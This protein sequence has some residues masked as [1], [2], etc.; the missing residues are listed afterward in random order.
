MSSQIHIIKNNEWSLFYLPTYKQY[1]LKWT[2]PI[3]IELF[4]SF[5][6]V[7]T[8]CIITKSQMDIFF[9]ADTVSTLNNKIEFPTQFIYYISTQCQNLIQNSNYCFFDLIPDYILCI[10]KTKYVYMSLKTL[11]T[12]FNQT[13]KK[14]IQILTPYNKNTPCLPPEL[15][16]AD[17]LPIIISVQTFFYCIGQCIALFSIEPIFISSKYQYFINRATNPNPNKRCLIFI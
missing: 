17:N 16:F 4:N 12:T 15:K 14:Y 6:Q 13:N 8:D 9:K 3:P 10:D 1:N 7:F 5:K 2:N 11:T